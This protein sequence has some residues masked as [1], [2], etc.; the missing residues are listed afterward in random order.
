M[1][2]AHCFAN[3]RNMSINARL[4]CYDKC[5]CAKATRHMIRDQSTKVQDG[6]FGI[7]PWAW[8]VLLYLWYSISSDEHALDQS[9]SSRLL[10]LVHA[11]IKACVFINGLCVLSRNRIMKSIDTK[12][13][14]CD[15]S[16]LKYD[17]VSA[18]LALVCEGF[19]D[20]LKSVIASYSSK[21]L[22]QV[23]KKEFKS[24]NIE[25]LTT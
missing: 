13:N 14:I 9:V 17:W 22:L 25:K 1:N 20:K 12:D 16:S 19:H 23:S 2:R 3:N 24:S 10:R 21:Y 11:L 15:I 5:I 7:I 6:Q 18:A 8:L 4:S